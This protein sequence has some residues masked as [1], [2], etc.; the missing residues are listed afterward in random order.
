MYGLG[1]WVEISDHIQKLGSKSAKKCMEHY[2]DLYMGRYGRILPDK[3]VN[4]DAVNEGQVGFVPEGETLGGYVGREKTVNASLSL[5]RKM[6]KATTEEMK[7]AYKEE[8]RVQVSRTYS[9]H[10]IYQS[11]RFRR[12]ASF[13]FSLSHYSIISTPYYVFF[14]SSA[15]YQGIAKPFDLRDLAS[16][17]GNELTDY[18]PRR[19]EYEVEWDNEAEVLLGDMEFLEKDSAAD[20]ELK[21][22]VLRIYNEKIDEREK[23]K[24]FAEERGLL[25][26]KELQENDSRRPRDELE[27]IQRMR[28]FA[29]FQSPDEHNN[30]IEGLLKAKELRQRIETL[31]V[32]HEMGFRTMA[33]AAAYE[34]QKALHLDLLNKRTINDGSPHELERV[35]SK[36][37]KRKRISIEGEADETA[38]AK[39]MDNA[40]GAVSSSTSSSSSSSTPS[41]FQVQVEQNPCFF[42]LSAQEVDLCKALQIQPDLYL[43]VK[44]EILSLS[45]KTG[46]VRNDSKSTLGKLSINISEENGKKIWDFILYGGWV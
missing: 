6:E 40:P 10:H 26:Y 20:R 4:G 27:L 46:F 31:Q 3:F 34:E 37:A 28:V 39:H 24:R 23:R 9:T 2:L 7:E 35:S 19:R 8:A 21:L 38:A 13:S 44:E 15:W 41:P 16:M 25:N 11:T 12:P 45:C 14:S 1:N 43:K 32:Y 18:M 42:Q 29:R 33:E 30:F 22:A 17:P 36:E 5:Y